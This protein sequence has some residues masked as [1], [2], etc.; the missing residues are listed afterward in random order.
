[1]KILGM[2]FG[3]GEKPQQVFQEGEVNFDIT[4]Q[5]LDYLF[6]EFKHMDRSSNMRSGLNP[7]PEMIKAELIKRMGMF[8]LEETRMEK[9]TK[10]GLDETDIRTMEQWIFDD[11][12]NRKN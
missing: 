9:Y 6:G 8:P 2:E 4:A 10:H 5:S 11:N 7:T 1:M 12:K 3:R